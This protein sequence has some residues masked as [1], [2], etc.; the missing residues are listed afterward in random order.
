MPGTL[1]CYYSRPRKGW[2][3][4]SK[5]YQGVA[6]SVLTTLKENM[7]YKMQETPITMLLDIQSHEPKVT[8][9]FK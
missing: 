2:D 7:P 4:P 9:K 3:I 6:G 8:E 5:F 1:K